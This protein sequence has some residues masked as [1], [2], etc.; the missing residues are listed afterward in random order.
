MI[1]QVSL[2]PPPPKKVLQ[3]R[4]KKTSL[5]KDDECSYEDESCDKSIVHVRMRPF[6]FTSDTIDILCSVYSNERKTMSWVHKS[7]LRHAKNFLVLLMIKETLVLLMIRETL[8]LLMI[9]ETLVL[10]MIKETLVLLM[11]RETL[12][13]LMIK[14]TLVLLMIKETLVLLMIKETLVLLM[15]KETLVLL[16]IRETLVLLMIRET[17][18]G[19]PW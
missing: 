16:M 8:V 3:D 18:H 6:W 14:E 11:I 9:K 19:L 2:T 12:V 4:W 15:I 13:L 1:E 5:T 7:T 17:L 10:L